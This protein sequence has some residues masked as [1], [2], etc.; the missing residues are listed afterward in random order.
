VFELR[1][2][3][4]DELP[5]I[6]RLLVWVYGWAP[7]GP[8]IH[9]W[10]HAHES[11]D[12]QHTLGAFHDGTA[13]GFVEYQP[14]PIQVGHHAVVPGAIAANLAV[15]PAW[16]RRKIGTRLMNRQLEHVNDNGIALLVGTVAQVPLMRRLGWEFGSTVLRYELDSAELADQLR[17]A[18]T[19][20]QPEPLSTRDVSEVH[21]IYRRCTAGRFGA[22]ARTQSWWAHRVLAN[23]IR[24]HRRELIGWKSMKDHFEGYA[25]VE[26]HEHSTRIVELHASTRDSY[27]G[28]LQHL[29]RVH[30]GSC[31]RW[32]APVDDPLPMVARQPYRLQPRLE[33]DK[34]FRIV[35]V[36]AV[37]NAA[38]HSSRPNTSLTIATHDDHGAWNTQTWHVGPNRGGSDAAMPVDSPA[39][40][41]DTVVSVGAVAAMLGS[42]PV[43]P[44]CGHEHQGVIALANMMRSRA[45]A[46]CRE[47]L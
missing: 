30:T 38:L 44:P 40:A 15:D 31:V 8:E 29:A 33:P 9:S 13:V 28:L 43:A 24:H 21:E 19:L 26:P 17:D 35:N 36:G 11:R 39:R 12:L 27:V 16:Q 25:V 18:R 10:R 32:S 37:L 14:V 4:Q 42:L 2:I 45:P 5:A 1:P 47:D 6:E 3:T 34:M 22:F 7:E 41:A 20:G 23:P 46:Y